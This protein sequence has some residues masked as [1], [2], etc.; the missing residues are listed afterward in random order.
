[1]LEGMFGRTRL[2]ASPCECGNRWKWVKRRLERNL[3]AWGIRAAAPEEGRCCRFGTEIDLGGMEPAIVQEDRDSLRG[4]PDEGGNSLLRIEF[5]G[6]CVVGSSQTH[7][8]HRSRKTN[9]TKPG[10]ECSRAPF[11]WYTTSPLEPDSKSLLTLPL[12]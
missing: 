1:M 4:T 6:A 9:E 10:Y 3:G 11:R 7:G 8:D 2:L 12:G 5:L